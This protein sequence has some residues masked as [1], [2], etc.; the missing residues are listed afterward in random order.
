MAADKGYHSADELEACEAAGNTTFV[1]AQGSTSGRST[2]DG[3]PVFAKERFSYDAAADEYQCP[4]AARLKLRGTCRSRGKLVLHYANAAACRSCALKA[5]CTAGAYRTIQRLR[6]EAVLE[7]A[8]VRMAGESGVSARRREI[9]EHVFGTLKQWGHGEFLTRG[10]DKVRGELS[11]SALAYN[12]KRVLKLKT[13][14]ELLGGLRGAKMR[15]PMR[16]IS[17]LRHVIDAPC[18]I[19]S[20]SGARTALPFTELPKRQINASGSSKGVFTQPVKP[21][22]RT[23]KASCHSLRPPP[24]GSSALKDWIR[25]SWG[26]GKSDTAQRVP[27]GSARPTGLGLVPNNRQPSSTTAIHRQ[28][29]GAA[30]HHFACREA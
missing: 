5:R 24:L 20:R 22:L 17:P 14:G 18:G 21:E 10:L 1:P 30:R 3:R 23:G 29:L 6:N 2:K 9:V 26:A 7:R 19:K 16:H 13:L 11:L 4:G 28:R 8:A 12:L 15:V 25:R 27:T